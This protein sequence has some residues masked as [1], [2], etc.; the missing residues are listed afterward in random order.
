MAIA[1]ID[2]QTMYSQLNNVAKSSAQEQMAQV[3]QSVQQVNHIQE[4]LE[5][6]TRVQNTNND[7][8][9]S[10]TVNPDGSNGSSGGYQNQNKKQGT[11]YSKNP[12]ENNKPSKTLA[13]SYVGTI[14]DITR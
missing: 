6:S 7:K 1:P 4:N 10:D 2:L 5:E 8:N 9:E 11:T 12:E 14:I 13:E 3:A